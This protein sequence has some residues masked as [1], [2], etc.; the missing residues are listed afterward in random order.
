MHESIATREANQKFLRKPTVRLP[1]KRNE[2]INDDD[3]LRLPVFD[4]S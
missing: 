4:E 1:K 2:L 3:K